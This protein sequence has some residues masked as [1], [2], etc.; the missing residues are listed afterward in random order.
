VQLYAAL[1]NS[2][3]L[4]AALCSSVH[5]FAALCSSVQ[6]CAALCSTVQLLANHLLQIK[7]MAKFK[8]NFDDALAETAR[9]V[10]TTYRGKLLAYNYRYGQEQVSRKNWF[11]MDSKFSLM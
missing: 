8:R 4:C 5:H 9:R 1:C 3:Q 7:P 11:L 2:V 6:P 10:Q